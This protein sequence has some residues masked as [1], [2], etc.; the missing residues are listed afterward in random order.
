[1]AYN[2]NRGYNQPS[3]NTIIKTVF[4]DDCM[5]RLTY[6]NDMI[7]CKLSA[8]TIDTQGGKHYRT[9][10]LIFA[11]HPSRAL[12]LGN[13]L[14][15]LISNDSTVEF[16][17]GSDQSTVVTFTKVDG[18]VT[19]TVNKSNE[20]GE[21]QDLHFT[22]PTE[23]LTVNGE[24]IVLQSELASFIKILKEGSSI[25]TSVMHGMAMNRS[26]AEMRAQYA[27]QRTSYGYNNPDNYQ[28]D[29]SVHQVS[30]SND[31]FGGNNTT[32]ESSLF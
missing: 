6:W 11:L 12:A 30:N 10:G 8:A 7:S 29:A 23:T 18:K 32:D 22:F 17:T 25:P 3:V 28:S 26:K 27:Q 16:K 19:M 14:E 5:M 15:N 20:N 24:E 9:D 31:I 21:S 13:V 1:M 2:N 4:T